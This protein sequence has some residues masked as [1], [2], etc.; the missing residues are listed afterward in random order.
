MKC[1]H[2][3]LIVTDAV[4]QCPGCDFS[5]DALDAKLSKPP[6][7]QGYVN[8]FAQLL[9]EKQHENLEAILAAFAQKSGGEIALVIV[10]NTRPVK[11]SEYVFWLF[12]HWG[13]G[14]ERHSGLL[15]LLA[16]DEHRIESEVGYSWEPII[17]DPESGQI[18]DAHVVPLLQAGET[19]F[20]L[21]TAVEKLCSMINE[22]SSDPSGHSAD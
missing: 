15:I 3:G 13:I 10:K 4:P 22:T 7:R 2:C 19:F 1:P 12:N 8:D 20:A 21:E 18:L 14:G 6:Q 5:I 9:S 11:P 17:T 16:R